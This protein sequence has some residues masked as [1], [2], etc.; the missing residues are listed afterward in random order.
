MPGPRMRMKTPI[1]IVIPGDN[2]KTLTPG[3]SSD[4]VSQILEEPSDSHRS[5]RL[6]RRSAPRFSPFGSP[7]PLKSKQ[8][9]F[10]SS[11]FLLEDDLALAIRSPAGNECRTNAPW[12]GS[13]PFTRG[14][15]LFPAIAMTMVLRPMP[16]Q[17][18]VFM[19]NTGRARGFCLG[20][21]KRAPF[22]DNLNLGR[23]A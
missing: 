4:S 23:L 5:G 13:D 18:A 3:D 6:Q 10:H 19:A 17:I 2:R 20:F 14:F 9:T 15:S 11:S 12:A 21:L 7:A 8:L 22:C 1:F 16:R